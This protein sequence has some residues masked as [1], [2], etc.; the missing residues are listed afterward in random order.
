[1]NANQLRDFVVRMCRE[2]PLESI[3]RLQNSPIG[4]E[5]YTARQI[6]KEYVEASREYQRL[7][8]EPEEY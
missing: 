4:E 2:L 5:R 8:G 6:I 7:D 3:E 1:M